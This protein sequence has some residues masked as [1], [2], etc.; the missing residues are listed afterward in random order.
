MR[1]F[2]DIQ[3][4]YI[5]MKVI[6]FKIPCS[7]LEDINMNSEIR[8][9]LKK[10][11]FYDSIIGISITLI[12]YLFVGN[13]AFIFLLGLV[14]AISNFSTNAAIVSYSFNGEYT[15]KLMLILGFIFRVS[16]ICL[17]AFSLIKLNKYNILPYVIG[18]S[19]QFIAI[20]VY[21]ITINRY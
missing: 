5:K 2:S 17:I 10:V 6:Q 12:S 1:I 4:L 14:M 20:I 13:Y 21:G 18:Y 3:H 9:M 8:G 7:A 19:S 15:N 16:L 11:L